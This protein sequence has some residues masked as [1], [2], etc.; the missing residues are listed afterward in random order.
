VAFH[1]I[2]PDG[3]AV[4]ISIGLRQ[5]GPR[6]GLVGRFIDAKTRRYLKLEAAGL[7]AAAESVVVGTA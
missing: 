3:D 2:D 5:T 7:K 1:R 6:A 4:R